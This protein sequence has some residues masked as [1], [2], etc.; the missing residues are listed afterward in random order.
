MHLSTSSSENA[1]GKN[2]LASATALL[3]KTGLPVCAAA[4]AILA[5]LYLATGLLFKNDRVYGTGVEGSIVTEQINRSKSIRNADIIIIGDSSAL[6]GTDPA[7]FKK[8]TKGKKVES[9]ATLGWV[10]PRG[11]AALLENYLQN[12]KKIDTVIFLIAG[13]SME[14]DEATFSNTGYEK[15][16]TGAA[17]PSSLKNR[18]TGARN[19]LFYNTIDR[20]VDMPLPGSYGKYYGFDSRLR[21]HMRDHNGSLIDPNALQKTGTGEYRFKLS[22]AFIPRCAT[23][24]KLILSG[25]VK[26]TYLAV[27]PLPEFLSGNAT[28]ASR[29]R[30]IS[31]LTKLTGISPGMV[32]NTPVSLPDKYFATTTHLNENGK[33][34]FTEL[35]YR[36]FAKTPGHNNP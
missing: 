13:A 26:H 25:K 33:R 30:A 5:I 12:N 16:V 10:G 2:G 24:N 21:K 19:F 17:S 14:V 28:I 9:L 22:D 27:A 1:A 18:L 8:L 6:M 3:I 4:A 23:F 29:K 36:N 15:T 32:L 34:Y 11:Y 20:A 31:S 7:L 35:L